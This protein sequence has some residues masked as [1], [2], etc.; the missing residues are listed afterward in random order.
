MERS[1]ERH[2]ARHFAAKP[3]R[4]PISPF[5]RGRCATLARRRIEP[6]NTVWRGQY[7]TMPGGPLLARCAAQF[8]RPAIPLPVWQSAVNASVKAVNVSVNVPPPVISLRTTSAAS[9][10]ARRRVGPAVVYLLDTPA[11]L[12]QGWCAGSTRCDQSLSGEAVERT[13]AVS[14]NAWQEAIEQTQIVI[15]QQLNLCFVCGQAVA[16]DAPDALIQAYL[17]EG[18]EQRL[19]VVCGRA[20][21]RKELEDPLKPTW[22]RLFDALTHWPDA[23]IHPHGPYWVIRRPHHLTFRTTPRRT[24]SRDARSANDPDDL[25]TIPGP[26]S[27]PAPLR[28]PAGER[29][30]PAR[31]PWPKRAKR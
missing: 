16:A 30:G 8:V 2:N 1:A 6:G 15:R 12:T 26:A 19:A 10:S 14:R 11:Q 22:Q 13:S 28:P 29:R 4:T 20:V 7:A 3:K 17:D 5:V 18:H 21:C 31:H 25:A 27:R 9:G 23:A 24:T